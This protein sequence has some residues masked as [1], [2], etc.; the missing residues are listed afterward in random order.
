M[1]RIEANIINPSGSD[2]FIFK[3]NT[4]SHI[5][6]ILIKKICHAA[7]ISMAE[8][9]RR[10]N[11]LHPDDKTTPQ[12]LSNKLSRDSLKLAEFIEL[13]NIAGFTMVFEEVE[14]NTQL[15]DL[16]G[17]PLRSKPDEPETAKEPIAEKSK[18]FTDLLMDG[19]CEIKAINFK[20][21]IVAGA[22]CEEAA[23]WIEANLKEFDYDET[24][25]IML[26]LAAARQFKVKI[27]PISADSSRAFNMI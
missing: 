4:D 19:Y 15:V 8:L 17:K 7:E 13:V 18:T 22:R 20:S 10:R 14:K 2:S 6:S 26:Y 25:E 11:A 1:K 24:Q 5:S 12:N 27:K 9:V 16:Q 23:K 3:P 21:A